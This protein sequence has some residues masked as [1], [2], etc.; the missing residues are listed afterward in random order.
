MKHSINDVIQIAK[1]VGDEILMPNWGKVTREIKGDGS[2]VSFVD[3]QASAYIIQ[4]L[5]AITPDIPVISEEAPKQDNLAAMTSKLRWVTD[6]LDGTST[7][8]TGPVHGDDAGFGVHIA[9]ID[10]GIPV[11]GV[12]YFPAQK[13]LYFTGDDGKAYSQKGEQAPQ[14]IKVSEQLSDDTIKAAVP[15]KSYKRPADINGHDF[16]AVPAVGGEQICKVASGKA[17]LMWHDRPDKAEPLAKR[18]VFSHWD[19][20]AAHAVLKAAGGEL[21]S[22]ASAEP[23]SYT[24]SNFNVPAC[25]AGHKKILAEIDF[26]PARK[27]QDPDLTLAP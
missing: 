5:S 1:H 2:P 6:P 10:D 9:L 7:Y 22:I 16:T 15:W 17:D 14:Q 3:R 13:M 21:Y 20:A 24:Q 26:H 23:V 12:C 11:A 19:V 4:A 27:P 25:V 18:D 8:L